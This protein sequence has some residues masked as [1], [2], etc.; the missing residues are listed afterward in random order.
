MRTKLL[1]AFLLLT[2]FAPAGA[3]ESSERP[4]NMTLD[5]TKSFAVQGIYNY[6]GPMKIERGEMGA[7]QAAN[8]VFR[9][10]IQADKGTLLLRISD[11]VRSRPRVVIG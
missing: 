2:A 5:V 7:Q 9:K 10:K 1:A 11:A 8:V 4:N 3:Q 6:R